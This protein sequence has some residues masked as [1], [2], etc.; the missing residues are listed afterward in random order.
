[1]K[2]SCKR[3]TSTLYYSAPLATSQTHDSLTNRGRSIGQ[4]RL[5]PPFATFVLNFSLFRMS[6]PVSA[7]S[8]R[9]S[10]SLVV[11]PSNGA[12]AQS[13]TAPSPTG[14]VVVATISGNKSN[15]TGSI[16]HVNGGTNGGSGVEASQQIQDMSH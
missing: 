7:N 12:T 5:L 3:V 13:T 8:K 15:N 2:L 6:S 10:P 16:Y 14:G 11:A 9:L 4:V 1:M